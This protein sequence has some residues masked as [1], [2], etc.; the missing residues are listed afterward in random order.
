VRVVGVSFV[1]VAGV[2]G[3]LAGLSG[4]RRVGVGVLPGDRCE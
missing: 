2:L 3:D 4:E 1:V